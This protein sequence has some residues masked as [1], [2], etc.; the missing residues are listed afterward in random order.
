MKPMNHSP[1]PLGTTPDFSSSQAPAHYMSLYL[2]LFLSLSNHSLFLSAP[3]SPLAPPSKP[4][5]IAL[6]LACDVDFAAI[7]LRPHIAL[8]LSLSSLSLTVC[9]SLLVHAV[10]TYPRRHR[11]PL[12]PDHSHVHVPYISSSICWHC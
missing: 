2:S 3:Q 7:P 8:S 5:A 4:C 1:L 10:A 6:T 9:P 12:R 11:R